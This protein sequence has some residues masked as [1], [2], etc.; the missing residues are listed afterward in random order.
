MLQLTD[1]QIKAAILTLLEKKGRWG[2]HYF[3]LDTLINWL[4][5]KVKRNS[6]RVRRCMED[7]VR[8][9]YILLHKGGKTVSLNPEKGIEIIENIKSVTKKGFM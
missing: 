1:N 3:P 5:R 8:E 7:L 6:K 4:G 2:A 9:D